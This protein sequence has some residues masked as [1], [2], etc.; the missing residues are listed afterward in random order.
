[1]PV[2]YF[3]GMST[4]PA[5]GDT[6]RKVRTTAVKKIA[7]QAHE[8]PVACLDWIYINRHYG[9]RLWSRLKEWRAI[10]TRYGESAI[11]FM[12]VLCLAAALDWHKR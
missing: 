4:S 8:A 2:G 6:A 3:L 10:A 9:E 11:S 7:Y 5:K 12:G 1:L